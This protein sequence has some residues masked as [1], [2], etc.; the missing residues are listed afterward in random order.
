MVDGRLSELQSLGLASVA[1]M[2][3]PAPTGQAQHIMRCPSNSKVR[4]SEAVYVSTL[5]LTAACNAYSVCM[6]TA[7]VKSME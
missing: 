4:L 6:C 3:A 5:V 7:L 2:H 1:A